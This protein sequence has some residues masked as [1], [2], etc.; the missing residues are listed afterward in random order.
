[1]DDMRHSVSFRVFYH[2][3]SHHCIS[4]ILLCVTGQFLRSAQ[5]QG[6]RGYHGHMAIR[7]NHGELVGGTWNRTRC[8]PN[9]RGRRCRGGQNH[10]HISGMYSMC[11]CLIDVTGEWRRVP[12]LPCFV[13]SCG[14]SSSCF[15][16]FPMTAVWKILDA[17]GTW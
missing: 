3:M 13:L 1:M 11:M 5:V 16:L 7:S 10:Q 9:A 12:Q 4:R 2:R 15:Y 14:I 8:R 17:Q 6:F